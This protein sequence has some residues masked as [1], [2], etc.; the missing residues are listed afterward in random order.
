MSASRAATDPLI[1][2]MSS[3]ITQW[4]QAHDRRSIFLS[5][6]RLMTTNVL[7][8]VDE[9]R[10]HDGQWVSRLLHH[11]AK[12]YFDALELFNLHSADTPQVWRLVHRAARQK[13]VMT[14]QHLMLG[15]NAHINYDLVF[16][17]YDLLA[18][19][20]KTLSPEQRQQRL[21]DHT[22]VNTII[23]ESI[24]A[25]QDQVIDQHS[26][27]FKLVDKLLGPTDEW[28]T[29]H[30]IAHWRTEVWTNTMQY[31]ELQKRPARLAFQKK[32]EAS[33]MRRGDVFLELTP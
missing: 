29:S 21:A 10:F 33:A 16:T 6:Y 12:Y 15:V 22:L 25:V 13:K 7:V 2:R 32:I 26:P 23:G 20:W 28:L 4:E 14:L 17:L 19:E 27:W 3:L 8:A 5:C 11:F 24:D 1:Q 30:L 18:P 9:H 31:I